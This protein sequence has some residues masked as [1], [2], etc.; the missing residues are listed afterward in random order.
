MT[1]P[2]SVLITA[3]GA[4]QSP[5]LI[6]HLKENGERPVRIVAVDMDS[7]AAGG[8]LADA[9]YPIPPAGATGYADAVLEV[10]RGE[11]PDVFLNVSETD[12]PHIARLRDRIEELGTRVCGSDS[13]ALEI[14]TNK[15]ALY[16]RLQAVAAD[17]VPEFRAPADL[18]QFVDMVRA[19]GYPERELC[20]KP[21]RGKGTRGFRILSER[22]DRRDLLLNHKPVSRYMTLDEFVSI[23]RDSP[24][25]PSLLLME[26]VTGEECDAMTLAYRGEALLTT[27]K[28]R[29]SHRWGVIDR[30][31]LIDRPALVARTRTIIREIPLAYNLSLQYIGDK[32]IEINPRTSTFIYEG[33]FNEPWLAIKLA[34]GLISAD[35]VRAFQDRVPI[36]RRM[37]RYMDQIFFAPDGRWW[38]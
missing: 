4:P 38:H 1:A 17:L 29:E 35:E 13:A 25:F 11:K 26:V 33:D 31:E 2:I 21:H 18:D 22:F 6:R 20:F 12:V 30:G 5:T 37:V 10:V 32:L 15:L 7:E 8:F 36:G 19:M 28:A 34:L 23:F 3:A 14:A 24:T 16:G 9:F 27:V